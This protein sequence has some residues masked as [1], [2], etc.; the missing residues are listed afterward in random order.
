MKKAVWIG[1]LLALASP[2]ALRAQEGGDVYQD[3]FTAGSD[4]SQPER[5]GDQ[6]PRTIAEAKKQGRGYR[7]GAGG[8]HGKAA[9]A[10]TGGRDIHVVQDGDTLWDISD[11]YF[12]DPYHWPELW[13]YNPEITNPH[14]IYP[15]DQIRL[16]PDAMTQQQQ[17]AAAGTKPG[18]PGGMGEKNAT[19][20]VLSGTETAPSVVIPRGMWKPGMIFL[21]DQG[22]LDQ[23]ALRTEGV[24]TGANEE[25]MFMSPSDQIYI[26]F[27]G[28][29]DVKAGEAY[30]IFRQLKS[31][32]RIEKEKGKLVR[33]LG[34]A[35]VRSYDREKHVAR[36]VITEA[37][38]PIER[39][40]F[41]A[42][43]DR[44]FDL[45]EPKPNTANAMA[46]IIATIQP[47]TLLA[48][49]SVVFLDIGEGHGI[50]PGNRFF[51]VRRGDDWLGSIM[52]KPTDMGNVN[53]VPPYDPNTM[54]KEVIAE[55]RVIKVRKDT[56]IALITRS[57]LDVAIGDLAEMRVGF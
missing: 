51:V 14:W 48:Y 39:G 56:T 26:R 9:H 55:L 38:D 33:V 15:L 34:T 6:G 18:T 44:R 19:P 57:D 32:E 42:K 30:T 7:I 3:H 12:G 46:H 35:V 31:K 37:M 41:V 54:P 13:S 28:D 11:H 10:P 45:V 50:Q 5:G 4:V 8:V 43:L 16:S 21:R 2:L 49:G 36:A 1:I 22:Y 53:E 47:H 27:D 52:T 29:R 23:E 20:G 25:N 24:I 40:L 17:V